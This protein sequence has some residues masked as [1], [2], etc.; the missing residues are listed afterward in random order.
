MSFVGVDLTDPADLAAVGTDDNAVVQGLEG[1]RRG[2]C[3]GHDSPLD[4]VSAIGRP[5]RLLQCLPPARAAARPAVTPRWDP[6]ASRVSVRTRAICGLRQ[7][8]H[9]GRASVKPPAKQRFRQPGVMAHSAGGRSY[10]VNPSTPS[11]ALQDGTRVDFAFIPVPDG[12]CRGPGALIR[13]FSSS[14]SKGGTGRWPRV[15]GSADVDLSW[16]SREHCSS[17]RARPGGSH[18]RR[19][20][21]LEL[22]DIQNSALRA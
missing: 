11:G 4:C 21:T 3:G 15:P 16:S 7:N 12:K 13:T 2:I 19:V 18:I 10:P 14:P 22:D 6:A 17:S 9:G 8:E 5:R 1:P 20:G